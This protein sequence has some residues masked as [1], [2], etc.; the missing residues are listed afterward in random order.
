MLRQAIASL[1]TYSIK[2]GFV[3]AFLKMAL[4]RMAAWRYT[5][6]GWGACVMQ[7]KH[8]HG[9]IY[10]RSHVDRAC[11]CMRFGLTWDFVVSRQVDRASGTFLCKQHCFV[12]FFFFF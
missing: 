3:G 11:L 6:N 8:Q 9:G 7:G 2:E 4:L 5:T 10:Q 12:Q 1:E